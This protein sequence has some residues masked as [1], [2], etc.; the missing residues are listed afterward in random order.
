MINRVR[1]HTHTHTHMH[2]HVHK[3]KRKKKM[4]RSCYSI[5]QW[6]ARKKGI[7]IINIIELQCST[8]VEQ[9]HKGYGFDSCRCR[10]LLRLQLFYNCNDHILSNSFFGIQVDFISLST[11]LLVGDRVETK[12]MKKK[13]KIMIP[14]WVHFTS[15]L[16]FHPIPSQA[17]AQ[18][19][20]SCAR[21]HG[22]LQ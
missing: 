21:Y 18:A 16:S 7:V 15:S 17:C 12:V 5:K 11:G 1:Y 19:R 6:K 2:L 14:P 22:W 3:K 4:K 9:Y 20:F 8:V 10:F 13:G